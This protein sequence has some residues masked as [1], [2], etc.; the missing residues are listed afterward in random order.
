MLR[1]LFKALM[2]D[3]ELEDIEIT[4]TLDIVDLACI[5]ITIGAITWMI[6]Q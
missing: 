2:S 4:V 1:K 6:L 5:A 3:D